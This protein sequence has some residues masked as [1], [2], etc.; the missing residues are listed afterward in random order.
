M[1]ASGFL[2]RDPQ[3]S[4]FDKLRPRREL[5][6][7]CDY[8]LSAMRTRP[9]IEMHPSG[10]GSFGRAHV[11]IWRSRPSK[12]GYT[13]SVKNSRLYVVRKRK[14]MSRNWLKLT[15]LIKTRSA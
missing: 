10:P 13:E 4:P 9:R 12:I 7:T 3:K 1:V 11:A 15:G 6:R 2:G 14:A 5:C 8:R